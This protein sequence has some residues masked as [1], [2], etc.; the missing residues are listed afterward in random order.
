MALVLMYHNVVESDAVRS[1]FHPAHRPYVTTSD[2]FS[3]HI[4]T[5]LGLGWRFRAV[6]EL[7]G[8]GPRDDRAILLTFD[9]SWENS[10]A[11][12]VMRRHGIKGVFFLN[13]AE[14]GLRGRLIPSD[15]LAMASEGHEIGS[16]GVTHEFLTRLDDR[17]LR[18]HMAESRKNLSEMSGKPVRF[19]SAP[20]GRFDARVA[21]AARDAGYEAFFVSVPGFLGRI[22]DGFL[23]KRIGISTAVDAARLARILRAPRSYVL[24]RKVRYRLSRLRP[25]PAG[26][27]GDEGH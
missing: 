22:S 18:A 26:L 10:C 15:V 4:E 19:L 14:I 13:S 8:N 5:A 27:K 21:A 11:V 20:G 25:Q 9:D 1:T 17:T 12:E 23:V 2:E 16:H 6:D 24:S 3:Q 7:R